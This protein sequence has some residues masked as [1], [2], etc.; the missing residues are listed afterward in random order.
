MKLW[1]S[2]KLLDHGRIVATQVDYII[3]WLMLP[4]SVMFTSRRLRYKITGRLR[5]TTWRQKEFSRRF[6]VHAGIFKQTKIIRFAD[7]Y[8]S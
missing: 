6:A 7:Y 2:K 5:S 3:Y 4:K 1:K 8:C